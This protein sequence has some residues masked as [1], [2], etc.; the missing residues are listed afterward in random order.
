MT[1]P[2]SGSSLPCLCQSFPE[3]HHSSVH[4]VSLRMDRKPAR[5]K[6]ECQVGPALHAS[7]PGW[8]DQV[9]FQEA[10]LECS[11]GLPQKGPAP[12]LVNSRAERESQ[13]MAQSPHLYGLLPS[14][15][16]ATGLR[17]GQRQA[18]EEEGL[19]THASTAEV[20]TA[21]TGLHSQCL[22]EDPRSAHRSMWWDEDMS[23]KFPEACSE[24]GYFSGSWALQ[25]G[26]QAAAGRP[27]LWAQP[28][29]N[30]DTPAWQP[31]GS[32]GAT[33]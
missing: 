24:T 9:C 14:R 19:L 25:G 12:H 6:R 18:Q 4:P 2:H 26:G 30:R 8:G 15:P 16:G 28:C 7:M 33:V 23:E 11:P 22:H 20:G 13:G 10:Q 31:L 17:G 27:R 5:A 3:P 21:P 29:A 1:Q 32:S